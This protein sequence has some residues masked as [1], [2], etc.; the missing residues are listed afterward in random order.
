MKRC[1]SSCAILRRSPST[2]CPDQNA[3]GTSSSETRVLALSRLR[4]ERK[5]TMTN[6]GIPTQAQ[7]PPSQPNPALKPLEGLVGEWE[8]E[9]SNAS[10]LPRSSE[11]VKGPPVSF[12]CGEYED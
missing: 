10:F 1:P 6:D 4:G 9:L 5:S 8:M 3:Q 2:F 7:T 11:P 12:S